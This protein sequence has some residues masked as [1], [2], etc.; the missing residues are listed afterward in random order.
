MG[1]QGDPDPNEQ[2]VF[3]MK[4]SQEQF[5]PLTAELTALQNKSLKLTLRVDLKHLNI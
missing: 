1:T 4:E 2:P 5:V 3:Y